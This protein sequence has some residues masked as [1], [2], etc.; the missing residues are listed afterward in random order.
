MSGTKHQLFINFLS[1]TLILPSPS[2]SLLSF[3]NK[4]N[5]SISGYSESVVAGDF[6]FLL[7]QISFGFSDVCPDN[8]PVPSTAFDCPNYWIL[9]GTTLYHNGER[10]VV[11]F[12]LNYLKV[13]QSVGCCVTRNG[14]LRYFIDGV[15]QN[16]VWTGLP[17]N[18]PLWGVADIY[19][20]AKIKSEFFLVSIA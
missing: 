6:L 10:R 1:S 5:L 14:E 12:N 19:G 16:I 20:I 7:C 15:D 3:S 13:G 4:G 11:N 2:L 18:G 17:I 9:S 8:K